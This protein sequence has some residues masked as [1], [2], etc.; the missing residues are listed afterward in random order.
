MATVSNNTAA[1]YAGYSNN[2][3]AE[4][5]AGILNPNIYSTPEYA[6]SKTQVI[7]PSGALATC[8][9]GSFD[10]DPNPVILTIK[11]EFQYNTIL[12]LNIRYMDTSTRKA[13]FK[14]VIDSNRARIQSQQT[15]LVTYDALARKFSNVVP[16]VT[17]RYKQQILRVN[18]S[19]DK[20]IVPLVEWPNMVNIN[21]PFEGK[22]REF[23]RGGS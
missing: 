7:S 8:V 1:T 5:G 12:A 13:L 2:D 10:I 14:Y 22:Y 18:D 17:R 19:T 16:Y 20:G 21:S 6:A 11:Q 23:A 9:Y 4:I 3:F 15:L